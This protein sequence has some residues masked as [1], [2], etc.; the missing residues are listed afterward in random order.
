MRLTLNTTEYC[1]IMMC[2]I[3]D[4]LVH[5]DDII[6]IL[7]NPEYKNIITIFRSRGMQTI[8]QLYYMRLN[9]QIRI[10]YRFIRD[11]FRNNNRMK[12]VMIEIR[13]ESVI[14]DAP[15]PLSSQG[16]P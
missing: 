8:L 13:K 5:K 4:H 16:V 1:Q 7:S 14:V 2:S 12:D 6:P 3:Y 15:S 9:P 11:A 10:K